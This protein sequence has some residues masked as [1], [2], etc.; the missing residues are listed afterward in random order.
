MTFDPQTA[1]RI[2]CGLWFAPHIFLKIK[3]ANLAQQTFAKVGLKPGP[4]FLWI[5]IALE[6]LAGAGLALNIQSRIAAGLAIFVL[7]GASYAVLRMNGLNWRWNKGGPEFM[8]FWS[9]TIIASVA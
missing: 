5:T 7:A 9:L 8:L 2:M 3:N 6:A 1:L 4:V